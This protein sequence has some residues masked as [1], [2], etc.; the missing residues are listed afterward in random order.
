VEQAARHRSFSYLSR[1][2]VHDFKGILHVIRINHALLARV[3]QRSR[4]GAADASIGAKSLEAIPR[5]IERLDRSI[6]LVLSAR[7]GEHEGTFDVG[8][9]C[10][11]LVQ[12]VAARAARQRVNVVLELNGGSKEVVGFENQLQGAVLNLMVNALEAMP[13][14][15]RLVVT[16]DGG[17]RV[18]VRV[19]DSGS[20][21]A[22]ELHD[23][24]WGAHFVNE[25][26]RTAIGL[27]VTRSIIEAHGGRIE[28]KSNTPRGTCFE[29]DLPAASST[30]R[31][32][33]GSRTH[34][35]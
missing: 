16:V 4:E 27:H 9:M 6:E 22:P 5:E 30:G 12:L 15:G 2:W 10:Q 32:G 29:I 26:R 7:V 18:K 21:I 24:L 1:D 25:A 20:G 31:I 17:E 34:R 3:I 11:R 23:R 8:I 28:C 13:E 19:C 14:A 35:G 33:N